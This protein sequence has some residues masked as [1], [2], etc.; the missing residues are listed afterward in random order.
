MTVI[1]KEQYRKS[2]LIVQLYE[3]NKKQSDYKKKLV[4]ELFA[5][6]VYDILGFKKTKKILEEATKAVN[7]MRN[8]T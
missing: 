2:L 6:K 8:N 1:T 5:G 4:Y 3:K 7:S